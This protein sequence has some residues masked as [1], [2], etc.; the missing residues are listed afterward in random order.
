MG[1][2]KHIPKNP[3]ETHAL[4]HTPPEAYTNHIVITDPHMCVNTGTCVSILEKV[5]HIRSIIHYTMDYL[6]DPHIS[7]KHTI[8]SNVKQHT[9]HTSVSTA[10][11][12]ALDM[13]ATENPPCSH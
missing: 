11:I 12:H 13:I 7:H 5:T 4:H 10:V 2:K 1:E 3:Q 9:M 6:K 8:H